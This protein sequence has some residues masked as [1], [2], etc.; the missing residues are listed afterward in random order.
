MI[1][2]S[3]GLPK[4]RIGA[5]KVQFRGLCMAHNTELGIPTG[6]PGAGWAMYFMEL[7]HFY[8]DETRTEWNFI[9]KQQGF[10]SATNEIPAVFAHLLF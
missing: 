5:P 2:K 7:L 1:G 4:C 10:R 9:K 6:P 3:V 8:L